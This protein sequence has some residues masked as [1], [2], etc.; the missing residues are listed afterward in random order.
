MTKRRRKWINFYGIMAVA[1]STILTLAQA[2]SNSKNQQ[3]NEYAVPLTATIIPLNHQNTALKTVGKLHYLGGLKITSPKSHFGG[4]SSFVISPDGQRILGISDS[5]QW[6]V[7]DMVYSSDNNL[8]DIKNAR[9][10]PLKNIAGQEKNSALDAEAI[11]AVDGAGYVVS[12]ESPHTL[13]YF[14]ANHT[15]DYYSLFSAH[16]QNVSFAPELPDTYASLPDNLGI[17]ALT[18][19][20]D[21]RMLAFSENT[22]TDGNDTH[23]Q[24]WLIGHGKVQSL[25]YQTSPSYKPTDMATLPDGDVLVL[26]RHF[27]LAK[28]MAARLT[29]LPSNAIKV[30]TSI[31]GEIIA[32]LAFPFNLDNMEALAVRQNEAGETIIYIMSDNNYNRLQRNL[33]MMF[34]MEPTI[35]KAA[36]QINGFNRILVDAN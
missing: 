3:N 16:A 33:L 6:L 36:E 24:G 19:L 5:S 2:E 8:V 17:E 14:Q 32:D 22:L 9:M 7:A 10:A 11:T 34:R 31:K 29:R 25:K 15:F 13:R 35:K 26:E 28:G 21:G 23:A 20:P 27:S 30:G 12:F 18:T 1:V 4:I